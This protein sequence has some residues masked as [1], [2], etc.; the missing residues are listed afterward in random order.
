MP[1]YLSPTGKLVGDDEACAGGVLRDGYRLNFSVA[2][3]DE[4][5]DGGRMYLR[6]AVEPPKS[7]DEALRR[8][9][10]QAAKAAGQKPSEWLASRTAAQMEDLAVSVAKAFVQ[11]A[12]GAGVAAAFAMDGGDAS[13]AQSMRDAVLGKSRPTPMQDAL[14][15]AR[16]AVTLAKIDADPN[17]AWR[18]DPGIKAA[19]A[20]RDAARAARRN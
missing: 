17:R 6:D 15:Q 7:I 18:H 16:T 4:A 8:Q 12:G 19:E 5:P 10:E 14:A 3:M 2:L 11:A 1:T 20:V 9:V 13:G